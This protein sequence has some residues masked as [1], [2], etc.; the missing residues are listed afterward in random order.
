MITLE[1]FT[2]PDKYEWCE[3]LTDTLVRGLLEVKGETRS[4]ALFPT[5]PLLPEERYQR[6]ANRL[7]IA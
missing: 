5:L 2:L 1:R 4:A 7:Q 6:L 3:I